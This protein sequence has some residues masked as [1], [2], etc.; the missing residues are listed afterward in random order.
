[1]RSMTFTISV[2]SSW[3]SVAF[4]PDGQVLAATTQSA[5]VKLW[6]MNNGLELGQLRGHTDMVTHVLFAPNGT[7]IAT[8][9]M[10]GTVR[11][12]GLP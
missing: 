12:W 5:V 6:D 10:D 11:L 8:A 1:M 7:A 9:S 3:G 4:S 2:V